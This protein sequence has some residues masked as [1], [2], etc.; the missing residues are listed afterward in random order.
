MSELSREKR[1]GIVSVVGAVG[2]TLLAVMKIVVGFIAGSLSLIAD[3]F[4]SVTDIFT[5]LIGVFAARVMSKPPDKEH[6]YGHGRVESIATKIVAF[7]IVLAGFGL[8]KQAV[9]NLLSGEELVQPGLIALIAAAISMVGKTMLAFYKFREGKKLSS[10][11]LI[12]DAKNMRN[13]V[14]ISSTVFLGLLFSKVLHLPILD[15]IAA[16]F[17]SVW[18]I[19]V[20]F[21]VFT[22]SL[23]ELM[24]GYSEKEDYLKIFAIVES[25]EGVENPHRVRIRTV[26]N[27]LI[28]DL[29]IEVDPLMCVRDA[30]QIAVNIE[31]EI[32]QALDNVY[33]VLVHVEPIGNVEHLEKYGL[34]RDDFLE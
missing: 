22:E 2:N 15:P 12:A 30:H 21:Q 14:A 4:D 3:G 17:V 7:I 23:S 8:A 24:E 9:G 32:R 6:P 31:R 18:I 19:F 25:M 28:I 16:L 34:C 13:D 27:M 20:G 26:N 5:S 11:M 10:M 1:I 29:D 33:D